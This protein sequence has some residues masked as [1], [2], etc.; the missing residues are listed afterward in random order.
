MVTSLVK[1]YIGDKKFYKMVLAIAI[2][3]IIQ[4]GISNFVNLLDN[5]MVGQLGTEAMSAVSI[6]N[7]LFTVFIILIFGVVSGAGIFSAQYHG[8]GDTEGIRSAFRFKVIAV[9]ATTVA[10]IAFIAFFDDQLISLFLH[11]SDSSGSLELTLALSKEYLAVMLIGLGP[12]AITQIYASTLRETAK[13]VPPMAASIAAIL[14]NLILN[15]ILIFGHFG[16]PAMGVKGAAIATVISRFV[17]AL[18]LVLWTHLNTKKC[19]FIKGAFRSFRVPKA[20]VY[21]IFLSG[22]PIALNEL[23]GSLGVTFIS[24]SYSTRG[25]DVVAALNAATTIS[26]LFAIVYLSLGNSISI[27]TGN[28][29]GTGKL[30]EARDT[31]RK[32]VAFSVM[33]A[34]VTGGILAALSGV[35]PKLYNVSADVSALATFMIL[36]IAILAPFSSF[37]HAS[38]FTLRSGGKVLITVL[39]DSGYMWAVSVPLSFILSRFTPLNIFWMYPICQGLDIIK[40]TFG[41]I[42]LSKVNWAQNLVETN[43]RK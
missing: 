10:G 30:E 34:T 24:Q 14:T 13:T 6:A 42:L 29:L 18:A 16:A 1:K 23:F 11:E 40:A 32:L 3:I 21:R 22:L 26:N 39:L 15:Y 36:V 25:L 31:N 20:L 37:A 12:T 2:P 5:V 17:E 33:S 7:Q 19:P 28:L 43:N 27:I 41:A 38:Y 9:L 8:S 35:I 4:N